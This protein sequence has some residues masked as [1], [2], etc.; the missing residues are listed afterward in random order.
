MSNIVGEYLTHQ[1]TIRIGFD[2]HK[3]KSNTLTQNE[4]ATL[5]HEFTHYY[6]DI[7]SCFGQNLFSL[8]ETLIASFF[9][10]SRGK[11]EIN[12][13][14]AIGNGLP[15]QFRD[16]LGMYWLPVKEGIIQK[17]YS[18]K[19]TNVNANIYPTNDKEHLCF[20]EENHPA[21]NVASY[22]ELDIDGEEAILDGWIIGE[23]MAAMYESALFPS[24]NYEGVFPYDIPRKLA[25]NI[26]INGKTLSKVDVGL[27]CEIAMEFHNPGVVYIQM[28]DMLKTKAY[29]EIWDFI[30]DFLE[31][32][33][34]IDGCLIDDAPVPFGVYRFVTLSNYLKALKG[35]I[36]NHNFTCAYTDIAQRASGWYS[37]KLEMV[38]PIYGF[39]IDNINKD[40][41]TKIDE[42]V[43]SVSLFSP[44]ICSI[45]SQN[46]ETWTFLKSGKGLPN[47]DDRTM[48]YWR[49]INLMWKSIKE[50]ITDS[51]P[52]ADLCIEGK[53]Q[54]NISGCKN[55]PFKDHPDTS[56]IFRQFLEFI[57]IGTKAIKD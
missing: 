27:L 12:L 24:V 49:G 7:G 13:K 42:V 53:F 14:E 16:I 48:Y 30:S 44:F 57:G 2:I 5:F 17:T 43:K 31:N 52:F 6:Q 40:I 45:D 26:T 54:E 50:Q 35:L 8:E 46:K 10:D 29:C 9:I 18:K 21:Y 1:Y 47:P 23:G 11:S 20:L 25:E 37:L 19:I 51:C 28:L 39:V 4:A 55:N 38:A 32:I 34:L 3:I 33:G 36:V 56:C 15:S 22:V 41:Q